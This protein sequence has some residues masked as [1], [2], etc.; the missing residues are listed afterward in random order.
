MKFLTVRPIAITSPYGQNVHIFNDTYEIR[1]IALYDGIIL[2][3][4]ISKNVCFYS[5]MSNCEVFKKRVMRPNA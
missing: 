1:L 4:C 5:N 2:M 3:I